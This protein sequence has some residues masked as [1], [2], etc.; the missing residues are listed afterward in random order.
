MTLNLVIGIAYGLAF[1]YWILIFSF[2]G[3]LVCKVFIT[4]FLRLTIYKSLGTTCGA[5]RL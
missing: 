3:L 5:R 4:L 1:C 2:K